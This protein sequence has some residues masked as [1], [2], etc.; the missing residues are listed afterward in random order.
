M[1]LLS[2]SLSA[3]PRFIVKNS[4]DR[5]GVTPLE[6][7][8]NHH[9]HIRQ[10]LN[11]GAPFSPTPMTYRFLTAQCHHGKLRTLQY[12]SVSSPNSLSV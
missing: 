3:V 4:P 10:R 2:N 9:Q 8:R 11:F 6:I 7:K 12:D 5:K 1:Q